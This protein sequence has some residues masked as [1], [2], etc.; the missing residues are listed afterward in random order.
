MNNIKEI[1]LFDMD[2]LEFRGSIISEGSQWH[3]NNVKNSHM[4]D[5]TQ[6]M[7][8]KALLGCLASFG[9][10]YDIVE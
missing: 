6:G 2:T 1:K 8:L 9:L 10:V 3:F 4:T 5:I 7:P